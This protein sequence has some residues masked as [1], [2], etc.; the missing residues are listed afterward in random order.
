MDWNKW[1]DGAGGSEEEFAMLRT[2]TYAITRPLC[3]A[4]VILTGRQITG[5][6]MSFICSSVRRICASRGRHTCS[7]NVRSSVSEFYLISR[8]VLCVSKTEE[9]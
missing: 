7:E 8:H 1:A 9:F 3:Y 2:Y 5:V 4:L 6:C